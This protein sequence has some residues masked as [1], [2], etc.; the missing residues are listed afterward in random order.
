L[1]QRDCRTIAAT[2]GSLH[3]RLSLRAKA[4][5]WP[6]SP[7]PRKGGHAPTALT[8]RL[9][10][11]LPR[12]SNSGRYGGRPPAGSLNMCNSRTNL[13]LHCP[14]DRLR[15][16]R[17]TRADAWVPTPVTHVQAI[18]EPRLPAAHGPL[19][20]AV[21]RS[22]IEAASHH[23]LTLI[24]APVGDSDPYG[25]DLQ[26]ALYMCYELHYRGFADVDPN[27]EWNPGLLHLRAELERTFLT[28][29]RR[30]VGPIDPDRTAEA[31]TD[32]NSI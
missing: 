4:A 14:A 15:L 30:D 22:L 10:F 31:V 1:K 6:P 5:I 20:T 8:Y 21:R 18:V 29:V 13:R 24:D 11:E 2:L 3:Q 23:Q 7:E 16:A 17:L 25:L 26:L 32:D 28:A 27:W 12:A 19:S 9:A